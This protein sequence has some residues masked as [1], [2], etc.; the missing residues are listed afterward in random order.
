MPIRTNAPETFE[1]YSFAETTLHSFRDNPVER[2]LP[3]TT[4]GRCPLLY[5]VK[6]FLGDIPG[7]GI[8]PDEYPP[9]F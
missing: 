8:L 2:L 4:V 7:I 6:F 5:A 3:L 1:K 9:F